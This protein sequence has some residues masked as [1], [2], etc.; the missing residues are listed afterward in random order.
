[1]PH[2]KS[3]PANAT[4]FDVFAEQGYEATGVRDIIR[5]TDLA[6]GTFYNYFPDK[7]AIFRALVE[8]TGR[9][10]RRRVR[11]ARRSAARPLDDRHRVLGRIR[12]C[13]AVDAAADVLR[14]VFAARDLLRRR[15]DG[16]GLRRRHIGILRVE[17][18]KPRTC[19]K[20]DQPQ[21]PYQHPDQSLHPDL[22]PT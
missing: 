8:E 16:D 12:P 6:S 11:A 4:A 1:M 14:Q 10:A 15:L 17:I 20:D 21:Q 7:E 2:L 3:L 5:R 9:E 22:P 13:V 18:R 19:D